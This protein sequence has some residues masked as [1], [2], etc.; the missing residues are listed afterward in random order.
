MK[1]FC[2]W[3]A[4]LSVF[5]FA[6][7]VPVRYLTMDDS[8]EREA[9][10]VKLV[11]DTVYLR[12]YTPEEI[13]AKQAKALAEAEEQAIIEKY[14][15]IEDSS[16]VNSTTEEAS[17]SV[18]PSEEEATVPEEAVSQEPAADDF[19][20]ALLVTDSLK[21]AKADSS[22]TDSLKVDSLK[23]DSVQAVEAPKDV[24]IR[25]FKYDFKRLINVES[26]EMVDLTLSDYEYTE[27]EEEEEYI[28]L[29]PEGKA[30]LL[31]K[32]IPEACSLFVNGVPLE[33]L[34]PD[35]IKN[36]KPG[37]YNISIKKRLKDVDW[38]GNKAVKINDDSLNVIEVEVE[39]PSTR[40][41]VNTVPEAVEVYLDESPNENVMPHYM[42]DVVIEDIKP[43]TE[44][45]VYFRKVGYLDTAIITEVQAFMPNTI[46]VELEPVTM[47]L[48]IIDMQKEYNRERTSRF[49]GRGLLWSSIV[50]FVS[51]G[52]LWYLAEQDWKEAKDKKDAYESGSAFYNE[53]TRKLV[54]DNRKYNDRG[55]VK[56]FTALGLGILG[57]TLLSV[58]FVLSF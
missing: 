16:S 49:I 51:A 1:R 53:D 23:T 3:L 6:R 50:P 29:Y 26:G 7:E 34:T 35:T 9:I 47:N 15:D 17:E 24:Y 41:T 4:L 27:E 48:G 33:M 10:F 11:K 58:G 40:L 42:S 8:L 56:G 25:L 44:M 38:W 55:D 2:L 19:E 13:A 18:E 14:G 5:S 45:M 22:A 54:E 30:N 36:I 28:P 39:R 52:V 57:V 32:S 37:K 12:E 46:L 21:E 43:S 20:A 31:V